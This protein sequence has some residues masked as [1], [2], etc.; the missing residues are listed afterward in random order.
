MFAA[1]WVQESMEYREALDGLKKIKPA[2]EHLQLLID[3]GQ[4]SKIAAFEV[5]LA[6]MLRVTSQSQSALSRH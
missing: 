2:I 1:A 5:W 3:K 4:K 6:L